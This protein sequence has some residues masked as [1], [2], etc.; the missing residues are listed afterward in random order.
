MKTTRQIYCQYLLSSQINYT[1][2][3]LADHVT[4]LDH[5]S[6][7][8]FLKGDRLTS[9]LVWEKVK[10]LLAQSE[11]GYLLFDDTV[12]DKSHSFQI[13]GVRRQYSGNAHVIIKGIGVVNLVYYNPHADQY[14]VLDFRVFDPERDGRSNLDHVNAMLDSVAFRG[15]A[16]RTVLMDSW[17]ATTQIMTRLINAGKLF[18]CPVKKNRRVDDSGGLRPYQSV[19]AL[20]WVPAEERAGKTVKLPRVRRGHPLETV[21]SPSLHREDGIRRHKRRH[22][23]RHGGG[24]EGERP[25]LE[26]RAVPPG[27]EAVDRHRAV[28]VPPEPLPAQPRLRQRPRLGVPEEPGLPGGPDRLPDQE[29]PALGLP[30]PAAQAADPRLHLE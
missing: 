10:P 25:P 8:R 30:A 18:Y 4:G 3:N 1:G 21:P 28:R 26:G 5:N 23:G 27:G 20:A 15:I 14:W 2:T 22:S 24:S 6:V 11:D 19:E 7:Y 13:S 16:Y 17:Y 29:G 12:L 9:S